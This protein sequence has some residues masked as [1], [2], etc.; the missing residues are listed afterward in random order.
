M[1]HVQRKECL[2][3]IDLCYGARSL[4]LENVDG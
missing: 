4:Y 3:S 2:E 1:G